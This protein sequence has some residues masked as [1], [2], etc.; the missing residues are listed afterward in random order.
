MLKKLGNVYIDPEE[1]AAVEFDPVGG[2]PAIHL[3]T[4][5]VIF[6][7]VSEP[8]LVAVMTELGLLPDTRPPETLAVLSDYEEDELRHLYAMG[9]SWIARDKD[10]KAWAYKSRPELLGAYW[11]ADEG[12]AAKL[13]CKY[14]F[15][16]P[17]GTAPMEIM[18]LLAG[19]G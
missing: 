6:C 14:D 17:G 7:E 3:L 4:G 18:S 8:E 10:G 2:Q 15:L 13:V 5:S 9:F 11:E 1:I 19:C 16:E 12:P